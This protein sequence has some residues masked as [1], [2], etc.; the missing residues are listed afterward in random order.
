M[1]SDL[2]IVASDAGAIPDTLGDAGILLK[3][4]SAETVATAL[5]RVVGDQELRKDL[6]AKGRSRLAEFTPD[7]VA[8]RL[9]D[10]LALAGWDLPER[11]TRKVA[12]LSSDQRCGIHHYAL[13][14]TTACARPDTT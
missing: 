2:P 9:R 3:D 4:R 5:E 6:I 10:A 12:V 14:L 7:R 1:R 8:E 11:R 13:S